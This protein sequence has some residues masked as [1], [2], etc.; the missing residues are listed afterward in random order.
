[1]TGLSRNAV[2]LARRRVL[3]R[4]IELGTAYRDEGQLDEHVRQ[5]LESMPQ[6]AI[7]RAVTSRAT[8]ANAQEH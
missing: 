8:K 4:L 1:M 3:T 7:V 5:A 6:A 2:Y